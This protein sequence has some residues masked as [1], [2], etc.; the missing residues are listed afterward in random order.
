MKIKFLYLALFSVFSLQLSAQKLPIV[1]TAI[2]KVGQTELKVSLVQ[3]EKVQ[4]NQDKNTTINKNQW[5]QHINGTTEVTF[6]KDV[7]IN[8]VKLKAGKYLILL[9]PGNDWRPSNDAIY[10]FPGN[11]W[12]PKNGSV[13]KFPGNDWN[14]K[15]SKVKFPG[16][17]WKPKNSK[18]MFP[19]ND[20]RP[21]NNSM[22]SFPGNDWLVVF[23][24][25][26][27]SKSKKMDKNLIA[28][29]LTVGATR[30]TQ[31]SVN[32]AANFAYL[33]NNTI[34][35]NFSWDKTQISI[36]IDIN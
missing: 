13:K 2:H 11:D 5:K 16:N 31:P 9:F 32:L 3:P 34:H 1:T 24:R 20:W 19:G 21:V 18:I 14:P 27:G 36:P 17:D 29:E 8:G 26:L 23:Y 28:A 33:N 6:N 7:K 22:D 25:N 30:L 12:K 10:A 35:L 15:D 4:L